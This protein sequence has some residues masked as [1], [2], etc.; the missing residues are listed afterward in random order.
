MRLTACLGIVLV[1]ALGFAGCYSSSPKTASDSDAPENANAVIAVVP[2]MEPEYAY[3]KASQVLQDSGFTIQSSDA[4]LRNITT[5]VRSVT[6]LSF[7][8][9]D[10][11]I[12]LSA[13]VRSEP[14]RVRFSGTYTTD[15]FGQ[16]KIHR[17]GNQ[18]TVPRET[19]VTMH[20]VASGMSDSLRYVSQ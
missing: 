3:R 5:S 2:E 12:Q 15:T 11:K 6:D 19:W 9:A 13:S 1:S 16:K 7:G 17:A 20:Q 18:G 10:Y 14:T 8:G 4:T